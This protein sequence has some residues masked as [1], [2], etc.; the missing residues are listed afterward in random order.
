M[1]PA[2]F[3][4]HRPHTLGE[5]LALVGQYGSDAK[6]LAGGQS[7]IPAMNFRLATP[8]VLVDLNDVREIGYI[9][10]GS[11]ALRIGGMTRQRQVERSALVATGAP[12]IA[13]AMPNIAHPAIRNRGTIGGSLAHADPAAELPAVILVLNATLVVTSQAGSREVPASEFFTGL[14]STAVR[15]GE[16]LTEIRVPQRRDGTGH[17]FLEVSRRQGDFALVGVAAVVHVSGNGVCDHARIALL[18]VGD[19][20]LLAEQAMKT[21]IGQRP[22]AE[23]IRAAADA[24]ATRDIDPPSDIHASARYRRQLA[25]VLTRRALER[26]FKRAAPH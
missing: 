6:P 25:N 12:L 8:S 26:A 7:L 4:Y 17:A 24:T 23:M 5:A 10:N 21:I 16:L 19:R 3:E 13:E 15:S 2:P 14:F 1:K 18:S 9:K 20:P 22:S 11:S